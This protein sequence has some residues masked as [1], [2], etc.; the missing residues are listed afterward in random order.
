[1][2]CVS[3]RLFRG[4]TRRSTFV[5][6]CMLSFIVLT[7][8]ASL[9]QRTRTAADDPENQP[10]F[11]EFKGVRIGMT[12]DATRKKLGNPRDKSAEMDLYVFNDTQAV[13]VYYD[14]A[15][16]V[17]AISIDFM[18]GANTIPSAKEVLGAEAEAKT[19]GSI[20]KLLRY[21]KA[22][23]WVSYSRTAGTSPTTTITMQRI[24]H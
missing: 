15:G 3:P 12:A 5:F 16:A 13:Q 1:M 6:A 11:S 14:K 9:A 10:T 7:A 4:R 24:D 17:T 8:N 2:L 19:D 20:Y 21:P 23:Y 22:G 18:S